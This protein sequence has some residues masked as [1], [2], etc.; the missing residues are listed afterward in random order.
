MKIECEMT[1][2][3]FGISLDCRNLGVDRIICII[4]IVVV[5]NPIFSLISVQNAVKINERN[6]KDPCVWKGT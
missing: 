6:A 1:P 4:S 2:M 3:I 5:R